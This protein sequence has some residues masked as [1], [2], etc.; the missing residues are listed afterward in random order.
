LPKFAPN[1]LIGLT[2]LHDTGDGQRVRATIT[3][4]ILD[5]DAENHERIKMLITYDDDRVE[6]LIMYNELSDIVEEQQMQEMTGEQDTF[7]FTEILEHEGPLKSSDPS[8]KGS[9]YNV[10]VLWND[11]SVTCEPLTM[12]ISCD[13]V[14]MAVYA[15]EHDLLD[16][17][18]WK[19][20]KKY[21]RR[22][23]KLVRMINANKRAQRYNAVTYKFGIRLP[24]NVKE[25]YELDRVNKNTHW[26]DAIKL[27]LEQLTEYKT[28]HDLGKNAS[29]PTGYQ[30]IPFRW[31]FDV[32][33]TLKRKA[34]M[35]ARGDKTSP[36]R[37]SVY[38]GVASLRSLRIVV[39][40][41]ELNGLELTGGDIGNAYLEAYT[42]EKVCILAGPE[43]GPLEGHLLRVDKALY[44]LRTSGAR[45]HAKFADTLRA[46]G[47][48]PSYADPDVWLRDAGDVYE[49]VVVY[50]DDILTALKDPKEFYGAIKSEPWN[51]KLKNVEEPKYHLG[52]DFFRD[53]DGTYCYGAQTYIKRMCQNYETMFGEPV[54][55][56]HT[57]LDKGDQPELDESEELGPDG[58]AKFQSLIGALQ[59]TISLS[60]FDVAH[61]VM[62]LSRFRAA[63]RQGHLDRVKRVIGY[64]KKRSGGAIRF[65]T[66]VPNWEKYYDEDAIRYD[67][68]ESV[69]GTPD[70]DIDPRAPTP[71]GKKVC[72][73]T[74]V[75]A[76]LMHDVIT[77]R[78]CTGIIEYLN[79]TPIDWFTKRQ[80]QVETAT[81]GS[82]FMAARQAVERII[83]LRYMLWSFGVPLDG[84]AW[85]F[86]DNKLVVTSST[87]PH[88]SLGKR[89]NALSYHRVREA[90]AGGWLR[91]EHIPGDQNPADILTKSLAWAVS[92][93]YVE[94]M[95]LWK[96][97]T[98][99]IPSGS[100][101]TEGSVTGPR[102][103]LTEGV[104]ADEGVA[105]LVGDGNARESAPNHDL[106]ETT[107]TPVIP[108][109]WN[110]Q[111]AVLYYEDDDVDQGNDP[112]SDFGVTQLFSS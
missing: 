12:M 112:N 10:K 107:S 67:W 53:K 14:T 109:L 105:L 111:Y 86:G 15:K 78:S 73:S 6:E 19:K 104:V 93:Y 36:P 84:P 106:G 102:P 88:S 83:D 61:A 85:M 27:E 24:R 54:K 11:L 34:R 48:K 56:F 87:I 2:F 30:K 69:Y 65:R 95:L 103:K 91:F 8:Y 39:F 47:F 43:F 101:N 9:S 40:L 26:A 57:P 82:E 33:N 92:R 96:G 80:N 45:F 59:W 110:N 52:G 20:L 51:Y 21:A 31:V 41:A 38:S 97:D 79:Q 46:L 17:A 74:F 49:Y 50:V 75:D 62:S 28:F 77:G 35:V 44:G 55:E 72:S 89:W 18:G 5:R 29:V 60:R 58:T 90:I 4:K 23:K 3:K 37:D 71:K 70:E 68:M 94:P 16:T 63:P 32:K 98:H 108:E 66:G 100:L 22:A 81:Y 13:P 99:D 64:M 76:N 25:A 7:T 1:E 42:K